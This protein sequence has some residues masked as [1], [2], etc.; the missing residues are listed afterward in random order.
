M[1]MEFR[2][3][4]FAREWVRS[5]NNVT[6]IASDYSHLRRKNPTAASDFTKETIDGITYLWVKAG[7][8]DGNGVKRAL[9]MARFVHKIRAAASKLAAE[10]RPDVVVCSST[11]PLDTYAGQKLR[12]EAGKQGLNTVLVHEVHDMWPATLY[13]I[14]GMSKHNP[15]VVIMQKAENSAYRNSDRVVSLAK[16]TEE[17]MRQHGL[18]EGK[19]SNVPLG[20]D[21]EE[22][23]EA[24]PLDEEHLSVL[25]NIR[26][27]GRFIVGYFGGHAL[28]N[29]L[30]TFLDSAA[31]ALQKGLNVSFVLVGSG[32]EKN[33]LMQRAEDEG[34]KNII[35]LPP[36]S[37]LEIPSLTKEF[38]AI[39][40]GTFKS[41][42]YRFGLA[43]N[44]MLDAM[45]SAKPV[46]CSI[47]AP[48]TWVDEC[49]CG[50]TV[51]A[52]DPEAVVGAIEKIMNMPEEERKE[53]GRRGRESAEKNFDVKVLAQKMLDIF[54]TV[55]M[56]ENK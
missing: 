37:K 45:M 28:S 55:L 25:E 14:G 48:P 4:Y 46:I 23:D 52:E 24:L 39:Y 40:I 33:R 21:T 43:M 54:N 30:D 18:A 51:A 9:S 3:Y 11:Y 38:D 22:W 35:F 17:Y 42:L 13:E 6:I 2:P 49:G 12:R 56:E 8:Y 19:W 10:Y 1:G 32:V 36:V 16:Y 29:A 27:R 44:K 53:M 50:I 34:I 5:G 41:E 20:I 31:L 26:N 7:E 15:F 47:T